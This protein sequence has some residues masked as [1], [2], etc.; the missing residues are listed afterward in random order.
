MTSKAFELA[1]L[2]NAYSD[3]ALSNRNLI[4]NGDMQCWQ[5]AIAATTA[6]NDKYST[7][8]RFKFYADSDGAFTT[9][10]STGHRGDTGHDTALKCVCTTADTSL[11]ATQ[12]ASV[13]TR[14][15]AQN[16]QHLR[17]G[18]SNAKKLTVS[19]W[20]RSN[21]TGVYSFALTKND[22][23]DHTIVSEYTISSAD[24]WEQKTISIP[25][26]TGS[27]IN[28]D[29][30]IGLSVEFALAYGST[31]TTSTLDQ[32]TTANDFASTNQVNWLD[33]TS[34]N[35]YL[36][37]FQMEVGDTATPFE[38]RSFADTLAQCQRY[39]AKS[40][41]YEYHAGHASALSWV[42]TEFHE[43]NQGTGWREYYSFPFPVRMRTTPTITI[44]DTQGNVGKCNYY[45]GVTAAN[46]NKTLNVSSIN[47]RTW[48]GY[49]DRATSIGGWACHYLADAEL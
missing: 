26:L 27:S 33:S 3:G 25:A 22:S 30:G 34:N 10:R 32:W 23:P 37:G 2:G 35:W 16:L 43:N 18:T 4:I 8:D 20:V 42:Q 48:G 14:L 38:Y 9:E 47:E 29:N 19:F 15:E 49:S 1:R 39:F 21:K 24:T 11:G 28:N 7:V 45:S 36:T 17:Y 44:Y 41:R 13:S 46:Y 40:Y 12:A 31:Y 6:V 5:R